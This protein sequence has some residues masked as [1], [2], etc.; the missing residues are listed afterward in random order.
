[1]ASA[2]HATS[3]GPEGSDWLGSK[4]G[5][6]SDAI[7]ST[8][9][10]CSGVRPKVKPLTANGRPTAHHRGRLAQP[11]RKV[12]FLTGAPAPRARLRS[13]RERKGLAASSRF[14]QVLG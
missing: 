5:I 11:S 3:A 12:Q 9:G 6:V 10:S 1:M 8:A 7:C 13:V 2:N 14:Q 4:A